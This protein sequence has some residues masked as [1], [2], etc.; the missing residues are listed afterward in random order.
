MMANGLPPSYKSVVGVM[1]DI[2]PHPSPMFQ[3]Q[4]Q[5]QQGGGTPIANGNQ[6]DHSLG[7]S[8]ERQ[9][10]IWAGLFHYDWSF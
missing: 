6:D 1:K 7:M 9:L 8:W 2:S 5:Q 3:A 4:P 10:E